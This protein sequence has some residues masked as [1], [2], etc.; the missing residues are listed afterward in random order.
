MPLVHTKKWAG[1]SSKRSRKPLRQHGLACARRAV[2]EE[3]V[4]ARSRH[5]ERSL[6]VLLAPDLTQAGRIDRRPVIG[7]LDRARG[8]RKGLAAEEMGD[9]AVNDLPEL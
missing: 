9:V 7:R 4:T 8:L 3:A 1:V 5:H 2:Q 6:R